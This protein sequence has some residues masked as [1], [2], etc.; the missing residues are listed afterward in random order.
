M[1]LRV[2]PLV[3]ALS[4]VLTLIGLLAALWHVAWWI[5]IGFLGV[6]AIS[7]AIVVLSVAGLEPRQLQRARDNRRKPTGQPIQGSR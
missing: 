2:S 4:V 5:A 1:V 3:L 7:T 6:L